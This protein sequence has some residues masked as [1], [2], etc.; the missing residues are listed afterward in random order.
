MTIYKCPQN[1]IDF[2]RGDD[3]S[4]KYDH[5]M[6]WL[7][8][9]EYL[10]GESDPVQHANDIMN[11]YDFIAVTERMDESLVVLSMLQN[12]PLSDVLYLSG[13]K[14][15][16]GWDDGMFRGKCT[17][18]VPSFI[19]PGMEEFFRTPEFQDMVRYDHVIHQ[20]ANHNG[21][22]LRFYAA[23]VGDQYS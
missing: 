13:A 8:L 2:I 18:I 12:I 4:S 17:Y 3:S 1:L 9:S 19:S 20:A 10:P 6:R 14:G 21:R 16:G 22:Q 23:G 15:Q 5:Y 11:D 7:S